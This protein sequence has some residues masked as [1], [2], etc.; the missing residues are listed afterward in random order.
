M[1]ALFAAVKAA[2]TGV[3]CAAGEFCHIAD[4]L[5]SPSLLKRLLKGR[6][7][8]C[9]RMSF[10]PDGQVIRCVVFNPSARERVRP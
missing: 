10:S 1:A 6:G 8:G 3:I 7:W 9:S 2:H 5:S 4:T